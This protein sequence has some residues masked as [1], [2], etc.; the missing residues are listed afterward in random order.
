MS[1]LEEI[2]MVKML[3]SG[4]MFITEVPD[5]NGQLLT[6]VKNKRRIRNHLRDLISNMDSGGIDH[7]RLLLVCLQEDLLLQMVEMF[8][9]RIELEEEMINS[10]SGS[11]MERLRQLDL[12]N[13]EISHLIFQMLEEKEEEPTSKFGQ[14]IVDGGRNSC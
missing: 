10:K 12:N 5:K 1:G 3:L 2:E 13:I 7:S 8:L 6:L 4:G 11:S 14:Q 9:L